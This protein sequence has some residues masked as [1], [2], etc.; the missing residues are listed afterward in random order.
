MLPLRRGRTLKVAVPFLPVRCVT[1]LT[2]APETVTFA[3]RSA[4]PAVVLTLTVSVEGGPA[5]MRPAR[6]MRGARGST[7]EP[8]A[9][10]PRLSPEST[11]AT[12]QYR[13]PPRL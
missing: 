4:W 13:R 9:Y 12:R 3:L 11:T 6:P 10:A 8:L 1:R 2:P 7:N 5:R